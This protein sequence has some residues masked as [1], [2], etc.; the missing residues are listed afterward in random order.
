MS[1]KKSQIIYGQISKKYE[2]LQ[3][4]KL[5]RTYDK[6]TG[7]EIISDLFIINDGERKRFS[8]QSKYNEDF[9]TNSSIIAESKVISLVSLK[10]CR[11]ILLIS[12]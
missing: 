11:V 4:N 12:L 8:N 10:I 6:E 5:V 1:N 3:V 9:Y 7:E 2:P